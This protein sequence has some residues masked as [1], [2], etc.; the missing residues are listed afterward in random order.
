MSKD[1]TIKSITFFHGI[2]NWC[3]YVEGIKYFRRTC[4]VCLVR[5]KLEQM[6]GDGLQLKNRMH[7]AR[8]IES[9][10]NDSRK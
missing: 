6:D 10:Y 8:E 5:I 7:I 9:G 1:T 3:K 4:G 2:V